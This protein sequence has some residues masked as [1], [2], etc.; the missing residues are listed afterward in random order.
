MGRR[1]FPFILGILPALWIAATAAGLLAEDVDGAKRVQDAQALEAAGK[2]AEAVQAWKAIVL[3]LPPERAYEFRA[4]MD[5]AWALLY[6][7]GK[8]Q[9]LED[10]FR[11]AVERRP[12]DEVSKSYLALILQTRGNLAQAEP[13]YRELA[14]TG[15]PSGAWASLNLGVLRLQDPA[16]RAEAADAFLAA[17]RGDPQLAAAADQADRIALE[18]NLRRRFDDCRRVW[19]ALAE[20]EGLDPARRARAFLYLEMLEYQQGRLDEAEALARRALDLSPNDPEMVNNLALVLL[21]KNDEKGTLEALDRA[22]ALDPGFADSLEVLGTYHLKRRQ[23]DRALEFFRRGHASAVAALRRA[24]ADFEE[25]KK[26]GGAALAEPEALTKARYR[27]FR[28][29]S[30]LQ[31]LAK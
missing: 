17:V 25:A 27:V 23:P 22:L 4:A 24:K 3:E 31:G 14:K 9:E 19:R 12:A 7:A 20:V 8:Y 6:A 28:L 18:W 15:G 11:T 13:L 5:R 29:E 2:A 26:A 10:L 16:R 30:F 21:A 1:P